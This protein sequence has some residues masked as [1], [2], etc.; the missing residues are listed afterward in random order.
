MALLDNK[1]WDDPVSEDPKHGS[2]E[3]W[4]L[5]NT[6]GD[7]HPIH[8]HVVQFQI[9]NRQAFNTNIFEKHGKL[10]FN[11]PPRPPAPEEQLAYKDT[12]KALPGTVTRLIMKF[13]LPTGTKVIP[14]HRYQFV[15]HCHILEHEDNE[16]MRPYDIVG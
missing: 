7:A 10:V 6:T 5:V 8:I 13:E 11:G 3:I 4:E 16:M 12:A 15:W 14:G 1:N 2:I 9:L